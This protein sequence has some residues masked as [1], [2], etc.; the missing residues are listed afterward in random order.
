MRTITRSAI[1]PYS[2][3]AMFALVADVSAYPEFLPWC[4]GADVMTES[5]QEVVASLALSQGPLTS[6]FT[7][8]NRKDRPDRIAMQ[9][10]DGPISDH[11]GLWVFEPL[12]EQ[13]CKIALEMQFAFSNPL[14]DQL[15]GGAFEQ[16]C[17]RLVDAFVRRAADVYA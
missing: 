11:Q 3:E 2:A 10:V 13:G 15:F 12:G 16:S 4:V 1:V 7:T 9:L 8:R 14:K 17:N 6:R 5:P